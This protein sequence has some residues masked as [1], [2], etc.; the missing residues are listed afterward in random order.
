MKSD[1]SEIK[2]EIQKTLISIHEMTLKIKNELDTINGLINKDGQLY[3]AVVDANK[4]LTTTAKTMD[5]NVENILSNDDSENELQFNLGNMLS[6]ASLQE[7]ISA[8]LNKM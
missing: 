8:C 7:K 3:A 5:I 1:G 6:A 4:T 2:L